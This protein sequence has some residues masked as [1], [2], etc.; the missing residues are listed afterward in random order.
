[1]KRFVTGVCLLAGLLLAGCGYHAPAAGDQWLGGG[2]GPLYVE[3]FVNQTAEPYLDTLV[4]DEISAQFARSR[5]VELTSRNSAASLLMTGSITSF[6]SSPLAYNP[7]DNISQY[8]AHLAVTA[9]LLRRSDN[10]VLWEGNLSRS[11]IYAAQSDKSSQRT[12]ERLAAR[13]AARRLAEDLMARLL[14]DF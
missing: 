14:E 2:R 11:E 6:T 4:T 13:V 8:Q 12:G 7:N 9:R 3:L 10:A 1:M 5:L